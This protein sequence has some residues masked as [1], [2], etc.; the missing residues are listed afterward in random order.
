MMPPVVTEA[1][2]KKFNS[3]KVELDERSRRIWAATEALAIGHG[4]I[5]AVA[6]ATGIAESTIRIGKKELQQGISTKHT[7]G[8]PRRIRQK[9]GGRKPLT[10]FDNSLVSALDALVEPGARGDPMSP[11]RWTC[12]STRKLAKEL[13]KQGHSVSH[14]KVAQLLRTLGYSLQGTRKTKEGSTP[15]MA[16]SKSPTCG[17]PKI[18]HL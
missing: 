12:K 3:L 9:G 8:F 16:T 14:T 15:R 2:S 11:L 4:G 5:K 6:K 1:L 17:H 18:P 13:K 10:E 7:E